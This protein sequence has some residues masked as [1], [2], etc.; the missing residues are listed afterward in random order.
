MVLTTLNWTFTFA[1]TRSNSNENVAINRFW[2]RTP[3]WLR[4]LWCLNG[5][6]NRGILR[7]RQ[8]KPRNEI[9]DH[10]VN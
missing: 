7:I 9:T 2:N 1:A 8:T 6:P 3:K 10:I 5:F 4:E